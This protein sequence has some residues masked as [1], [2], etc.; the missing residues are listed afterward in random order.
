[1]DESVKSSLDYLRQT[2]DRMTESYFPKVLIVEDCPADMT[3]LKAC[4]DNFQCIVYCAETGEE[5][6]EKINTLKP[7]I[8]FIDIRLPR[9]DGRELAEWS[10][11]LTN[12]ILVTGF[13]DCKTESKA[14]KAG[15]SIVLEKPVKM[16]TLATILKPKYER[17]AS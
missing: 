3:L 13:P 9:M 4:L 11:A 7:D 16:E 12:V 1:M 2:L 14:I 15:A 6:M 8:T 10:K 5:A 17:Q